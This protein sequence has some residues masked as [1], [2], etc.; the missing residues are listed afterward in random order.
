M[1]T[2]L[3]RKDCAGQDSTGTPTDCI[4][5]AL[6]HVCV[7]VP[8]RPRAHND[9]MYLPGSKRSQHLGVLRYL[10]R[11]PG[12]LPMW[13]LGRLAPWRLVLLGMFLLP[14]ARSY[15]FLLLPLVKPRLS[16]GFAG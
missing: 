5:F 7:G 13:A 16:C 6:F 2:L 15:P 14:A 10:V 3:E 1:K 4:L 12:V 11:G 9:N 8:G